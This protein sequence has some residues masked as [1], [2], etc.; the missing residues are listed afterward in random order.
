[1]VMDLNLIPENAVYQLFINMPASMVARGRALRRMWRD[2]TST[3]AFLREHHFHRSRRPM[4]LFFYRLDHQAVPFDDHVR[5]HLRAVD[6]HRRESFPVFR[7]AHLDLS[8]PIVDPRVFRI[9]GSCDGLLLLSYSHSLCVC[10]PCTRRWARLPSLHHFGDIVGFYPRDRRRG[11]VYRVLYHVGRDTGDCMYSILGLPEHAAKFIGRPT[12]LGAGAMIDTA[13]AGGI[14]P[15]FEMPPVLVDECLHWRPH[16]VYQDNNH[17][18]VFD[19][20]AELFSWI[21]PPRVLVDGNQWEVDGEQI[22]EINGRLAMIVVAPTTVDVWVLQDRIGQVW[23][24]EYQIQLPVAA[25]QANLGY[26]VTDGYEEPELSAAVFAVSVE[27]NVLIQC[28][29]ALLQCDA[30]GTVLQT[31]QLPANFT[32]LSGFMLQESLLPHAFLPLRHSDAHGHDPPFFR[33]P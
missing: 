30:N 24:Y 18:L 9:Q 33:A 11:R 20:V 23:A 28:S 10:N 3:E 21:R 26:V 6:I 29:H 2:I 4:P 8:L 15:S 32:V 5:V 31:Y 14:S 27:R 12:N 7:F 25:I 17:L 22:F 19:T 16:A 1:V 13:L